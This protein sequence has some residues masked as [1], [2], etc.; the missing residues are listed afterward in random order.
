MKKFLLL[1][2]GFIYSFVSFAQ[3]PVNDACAGATSLLQN[4]TCFT[5]TTLN[6]ADNWVGQVGCQNGNNSEVW[7]SFTSTGT[8]GQFTITNG[9]Q[10]G[11]V[12]FILVS[13]TSAC[14]GLA[15][16]NSTCGA[17][18]LNVSV[19]LTPGQLYYATI[20]ST[21]A[22]GT[23]NICLTT[24]TPPPTPGQ[25]CTNAAILC[26]SNSITQG[27]F[28]GIG[29]VE[30]VATNTCFNSNE[31]QSKWYKFSAGC[32]GTWEMIIDPNNNNDDYDWALWNTTA[33]CYST[34]S[35]MGS[36]VACNWSGCPGNTGVTTQNPCTVLNFDCTGN[37]NDCSSAQLN[38]TPPN[39]VAGQVYSLL[40]DNFTTS[41]NGFTVNFG[42]SAIIG[43]DAAFTF[44]YSGATGCTVST[45]KTC[46][47]SPTTNSTY[48]WTW[49]DGA[50]STTMNASH[51]YAVAG[52]YI[53]TYKVTD[54]L[55]CSRTTSQTVTPCLIALPIELLSISAK[56]NGN[57]S[58]TLSWVTA[59]EKDIDHYEIERSTDANNFT[60]IGNLDSKS[61]DGNSNSYLGYSIIDADA[62]V[63]TDLYYR[64][65]H[66]NKI[67]GEKISVGITS[68]L[69]QGGIS[70]LQVVPNP[71]GDFVKL[72]FS[73]PTK[74]TG[75]YNVY[76]FSGKLVKSVP[77]STER[78]ANEL[79]ADFSSV[80]T[81]FYTIE[82]K[83]G[84][85]ILQSK[86]IKQ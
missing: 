59:S 82:L 67:N 34:A 81:G 80:P 21:G 10:G 63:N 70:G 27:T 65:S 14:T 15:I 57:Q 47:I 20:S 73:S 31:R 69:V 56:D 12:E 84:N 74:I 1:C 45:T 51:T 25:D 48:L 78:G 58:A 36:A 2:F 64:L 18:P 23:F 19:G 49:G 46:A 61:I 83:A 13:A 43:P 39:L 33:A 54:L 72:S 24:S 55:G 50:S 66:V 26:N 41:G 35:T 11:N 29:T 9:T 28:T 3:A 6:A 86:F 4:G 40:I 38:V 75:E 60:W 17:S 68:V 76:D 7:Y 77:F 71:G 16:V 30:N 85:K 37:P 62:P 53:I 79:N 32:S 8:L 22:T 5:G 44:A 52:T 42:G